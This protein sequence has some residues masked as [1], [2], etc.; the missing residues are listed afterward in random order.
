MFCQGPERGK[1]KVTKT[2]S[3]SC[4]RTLSKWNPISL[5][6]QFLEPVGIMHARD[7]EPAVVVPPGAVVVAVDG[8]DE[9][10]GVVHDGSALGGWRHRRRKI[11]RRHHHRRAEGDLGANIILV[12]EIATREIFVMEWWFLYFSKTK[13]ISG[14]CFYLGKL[15]LSQ[16][17]T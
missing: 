17:L 13:Y 3:T 11:C 8:V 15:Q 16:L 7:A 6:N 5:W 4:C 10:G 1:N 12:T 14:Y 2:V 9:P